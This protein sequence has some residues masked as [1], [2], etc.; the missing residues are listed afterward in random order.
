MMP[1]Q[2]RLPA[3]NGEHA[4]ILRPEP[5]A[6]TAPFGN[7]STGDFDDGFLRRKQRRNRTTFTLQQLEALEAVFAQT[8]YPDV[9]TREELAMKINLTEARVQVWFQNRRAKWRKTERGASDQEPGAKEP[10][11]EV[12]PPPVRNINSPPPGDQARS[13]KEVLEAQQS[14]G[15]TVGP[16]GPFFPSCLPGTLLN[17]A[18]YAQALSHVASL[19]GEFGLC[20]LL[21]RGRGSACLRHL[22]G[23]HGDGLP[24]LFSWAG[25]SLHRGLV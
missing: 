19:K 16:T 17:T 5:M 14:L 11:A 8:H 9:F 21:V 2:C 4:M 1:G 18:T 3:P 13:K 22:Q 15:R 20:C 23:D 7:H 6:G 10:M 24:L 25:P 12:T